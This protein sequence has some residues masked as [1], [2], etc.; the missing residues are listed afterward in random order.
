MFSGLMSFGI[1]S[2]SAEITACE[3]V[4]IPAPS[5]GMGLFRNN[6]TQEIIIFLPADYDSSHKSYPVVY[7]QVFNLDFSEDVFIYDYY[8][9]GDWTE[10]ISVLTWSNLIDV[11]LTAY[12]NSPIAGF[13]EDF[14]VNDVVT[15]M[16]IHY[17]TT[18][19]NG[20]SSWS[21]WVGPRHPDT[22]KA[23]QIPN[24]VLSYEDGESLPLYKNPDYISAFL[25]HQAAFQATIENVTDENTINSMF[26]AVY[27]QLFISP[28]PERIKLLYDQGFV[29]APNATKQGVYMDFPYRG[30]STD[31]EVIP[32]VLALWDQ[33]FSNIESKIIQYQETLKNQELQIIHV[34]E[35]NP[36]FNFIAEGNAHLS[37]LLNE[38]G[39]D[40][41]L[42]T[43]LVTDPMPDLANAFFSAHLKPIENPSI[44]GYTLWTLILIMGLI[45][46][47]N[48]VVIRRKLD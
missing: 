35:T 3:R 10:F 13:W 7:F 6:G 14:L 39:I 43:F 9:R 47:G 5:L 34:V 45:G 12:Y 48:I 21:A 2:A 37:L 31:Y 15:Y 28:D 36:T 44:P 17:R 46:L 19:E 8:R 32:E 16:D 23:V 40:H 30:N 38:Y 24:G 25:T 18:G 29:Y 4:W 20:W 1:S 42:V 11:P 27:Q 41:D 26:Q 22:F 33:G